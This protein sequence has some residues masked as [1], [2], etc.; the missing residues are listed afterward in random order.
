[1]IH[2]YDASVRCA[3]ARNV[4]QGEAVDCLATAGSRKAVRRRI[5]EISPGLG[6]VVAAIGVQAAGKAGSA[7]A[8]ATGYGSER[9]ALAGFTDDLVAQTRAGL[10]TRQSDC[11]NVFVR[12]VT[13]GRFDF[14][15][16]GE[17][18]VVTAHRGWSQ[19]SVDRI[20]KNYG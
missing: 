11:T 14:I 3:D 5:A 9:L 15:V 16:E 6:F 7:G 12:E 8:R 20:A 4:V 13:P 18:G 1:V 19:K 2:A 17:R 10:A